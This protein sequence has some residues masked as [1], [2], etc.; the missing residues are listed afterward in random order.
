[1]REVPLYGGGGGGGAPAG[2]GTK[3]REEGGAASVRAMTAA[4]C[5]GLELRVEG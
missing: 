5:W 2:S 1:M 3:E 4:P